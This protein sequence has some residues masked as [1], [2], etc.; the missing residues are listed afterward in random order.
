LALARDSLGVADDPAEFAALVCQYLEDDAL[1]RESS[2]RGQ[3]F[4]REHYTEAAQWR[5]F[6]AE[7]GES[8]A[9]G[10]NA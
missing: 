8:V 3:A 9:A 1:W 6:A 4:V 7:L 2:R 10:D 5:A